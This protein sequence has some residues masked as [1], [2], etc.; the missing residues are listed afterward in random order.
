MGYDA[1]RYLCTL[2]VM[3]NITCVHHLLDIHATSVG[4]SRVVMFITLKIRLDM[5]YPE[6]HECHTLYLI[7]STQP[8]QPAVTF[9]SQR[10]MIAYVVIG[11]ARAPASSKEKPAKKIVTSQDSWHVSYK[12]SPLF[13]DT[14]TGEIRRFGLQA[15]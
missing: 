14:R 4:N 9:R 13:F 8:A 7:Q 12:F 6:V 3:L 11:A 15:G 5:S 10:T 1:L 2:Y